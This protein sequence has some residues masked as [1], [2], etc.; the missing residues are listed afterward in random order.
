MPKVEV[1]HL[2]GTRL[3]G[4]AREHALIFD[5][6]I[7]GGGTGLGINVSELFLFSLGACI[8]FNLLQYTATH[9]MKVQGIRVGLSDEQ[10]SS[11]NRISRVKAQVYISGEVSEDEL[12]RLL[13]SARGCKI[14][15]TLKAVPEIEVSMHRE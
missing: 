6:T 12:L 3:M 8:T 2:Q 1:R 7:E 9:Q 4:V 13:R 5:K 15:N 10:Q 14:H 11:P